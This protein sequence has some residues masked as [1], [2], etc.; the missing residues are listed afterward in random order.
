MRMPAQVAAETPDPWSA[1]L[2][3]WAASADADAD[4]E[5]PGVAVA[6]PLTGIARGV[7]AALAAAGTFAT[8]PPQPVAG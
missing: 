2:P 1:V 3:A 4:G 8:S 5:A 6:P 7:S